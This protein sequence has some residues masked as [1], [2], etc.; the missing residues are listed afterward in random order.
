MSLII[1]ASG[2]YNYSVKETE[3]AKKAL[4]KLETCLNSDLFYELFMNATFTWTN[5]RT[6]EQIWSRL[7]SG[8][9][10]LDERKDCIV[11]LEYKMYY[12]WWSRV[13]G[14]VSSG[15]T[16]FTNR[17]YF[18]TSTANMDDFASNSLH[19]Y[20]HLIGLTERSARDSG[21][22]PYKMN[23]LYAIWCDRMRGVK[24]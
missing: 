5:G 13:V 2:F 15:R 6:K 14:Y 11:N 19:E 9:D 7:M 20:C 16:I 10:D 18:P 21:C 12:R 17:K 1:K 24:F 23:A 22:V 8:A 3:I 4:A